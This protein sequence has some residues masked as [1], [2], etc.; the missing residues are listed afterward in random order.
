MTGLRFGY[1][2]NGFGSHRLDDALAVIADLGYDGVA[3]TLDHHHLDPFADD[4]VARVAGTAR[5]LEQLGLAVVVETGARYLLDPWRKHHPTLVSDE[6]RPRRVDYLHRAI[7]IAADLGAEAMSCWSGILPDGVAKEVG[8]SRL[9]E[10]TSA[11]LEAADRHGVLVAFEPEPGMFVDEVDGVL[12]LRRRL[13]DPERLRITLDLGHVVCNEPRGMADTVR[14]AGDLIANVQVDDMVRGV[15]D[16]LPLGTGE[17]DFVEALGALGE[18][19]Y[20][21]L[22]A[23]ELPRHGH[24]APALAKASLQALRAAERATRR[25]VSHL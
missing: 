7:Q 20:R 19:G 2:T 16:H 25:E 11:V 4:V 21:G 22:A 1:G 14:R 15:H 3:L 5:R 8:W 10:G 9:V 24:E 6:D 13:G 23:L 12:E 17:V 18:I